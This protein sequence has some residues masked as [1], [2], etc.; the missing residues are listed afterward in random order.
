[1]E[2]LGRTRWAIA[3]GYIPGESSF[4]DPALMSHETACILNAGDRTANIRIVIF[5][6]DIRILLPLKTEAIKN[7]EPCARVRAPAKSAG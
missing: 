7:Y 1:M 6:S 5:F 4:T 3:E 2:A